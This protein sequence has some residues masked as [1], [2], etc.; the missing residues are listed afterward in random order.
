MA[1]LRAAARTTSNLPSLSQS[2]IAQRWRLDADTVRKISREHHLLPVPGPWK[3]ARYS[4]LDVWRIEGIPHTVALDTSLR[5]DL[6]EPLATANDLAVQCGCTPA[7]IRNWAR[8]GVLPSL[9][10]GGSV[11]FHIFAVRGVKWSHL[12]GQ[13]CSFAKVYR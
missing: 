13:F 6:L 10:L 4:M 5:G 7:T 9:R 3:R 1:N 8:E 11:R 2:Q 12:F